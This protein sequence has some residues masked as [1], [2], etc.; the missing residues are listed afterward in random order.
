[1]RRAASRIRVLAVAL[2]LGSCAAL[3]LAG[4]AA[5]S[6][7]LPQVSTGRGGRAHG[8]SVLL[9]GTVNPEG[10]PTT[11]FFQY[12]PTPAY[13]HQTTTGNAGSGIKPVKVGAI[14]SPMLPGYHFRLVATN[15]FGT[16]LGKDHVY[17]PPSKK[18][19]F[20]IPRSIATPWGHVVV[21]S[22]RLTGTDSAH[23]R[24]ALD[25][26]PWPYKAA[27]EQIGAATETDGLGRFR[28][29]LGVLG[30]SMRM[31]VFT[32]GPRPHFS[33]IFTALVTVRVTL[34]LRTSGK[35]GFV[36][37]FGEVT[38]TEVGSRVN[39]QFQK[40]VRPGV[41][42]KNEERTSKFETTAYTTVKRATKKFSY[43]SLIVSLKHGGRYRA[44]VVVRKGGL[45]PGT[46]GTVTVHAPAK[47]KKKR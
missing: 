1:M 14:A 6:G 25:A 10:S 35:P 31:R 17:T 38:P 4:T 47:K 37:L 16:K 20:E 18:L 9:G 34:R 11:F 32:L 13:G 28:F 19:K 40:A 2:A 7:H 39:F 41:K 12:G 45:A 21:I 8:T 30:T 27:F 15:Q 3:L 33:G 44:E 26:T 24:L 43:F 36:R 42:E 22:G 23:Q 5:A 46:S 29:R